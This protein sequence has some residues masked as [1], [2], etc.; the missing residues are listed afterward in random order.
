MLEGR[1]LIYIPMIAAPPPGDGA[2]DQKASQATTGQRPGNDDQWGA[3]VASV[4]FLSKTFEMMG[5]KIVPSNIVPEIPLWDKSIIEGRAT[6]ESGW[7][8]EDYVTVYGTLQGWL[9][10][11]GGLW[12]PGQDVVVTSP[13]LVM[14]GEKLTLKS[15]TYSQDN[16]T[17]TR[18]VLECCNANAMGGAPKAGQ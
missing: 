16:Q 2:G 15:V 1:E 7:M 9:R 14:K 3:K 11:S 5:N 18:A 10:P 13:M 6:S 12:V 4:P 8:N 17:G